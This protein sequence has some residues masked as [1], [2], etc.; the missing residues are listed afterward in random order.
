MNT[1]KSLC[2]ACLLVLSF[3]AC[4]KEE[5]MEEEVVAPDTTQVEPAMEA[6]PVDTTAAAAPATN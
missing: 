4:A 6:A 5:V 2:L 3:S 1:F